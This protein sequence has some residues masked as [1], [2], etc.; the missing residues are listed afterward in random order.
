MP[1][2]TDEEIEEDFLEV[3]KPIPGQNYC[4]LSFVSPD[5][6]IEQKTKFMYYHY[7]KQR[8]LNYKKLF[9]DAFNS[10]VSEQED[11][12][13]ELSRLFDM[14][15][16]MDKLFE[17][18]AVEYEEFKDKYENFLFKDEKKV[19]DEFD[20]LNGFKT[21]VRGVKI[22]GVYETRREAE[23]R[24]KTLQHMDQ[25]FNIFVGQ[26]G[27][28][29]PWDPESNNVEDQEYMNEELNSLVKEKKKNE[30]KKNM[31]FE[32]QKAKRVS[33]ASSA[34]DRVREKLEK[35]KQLEEE[36][37]KVAIESTVGETTEAPTNSTS[38]LETTEIQNVRDT[39]DTD[40][41][42][43]LSNNISIDIGG[44]DE[45]GEIEG[46]NGLS[47]ALNGFNA[48]DPWMARKKIEESI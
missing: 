20:K 43:Q 29:L 44:D 23:I 30:D 18:D 4:C 9:T 31:F 38:A 42:S 14:K 40:K 45:P 26:V 22:R 39:L 12:M 15:K 48:E 5:K 17:E 37:K 27:Y 3:D 47:D 25:N 32:E 7:Q 1:K 21:S 19:C 10:L 41:L 2:I 24:A 13:V 16:S 28:W 36:A 34:A 11:G 8:L 33:E 46:D 35:K 6:V